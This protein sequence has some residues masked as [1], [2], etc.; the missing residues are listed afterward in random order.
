MDPL[1]IIIDVEASGFGE[2]SYPIE[3]GLAMEDSSSHCFLIKPEAGWQHWDKNSEKL[4]GVSRATL[5]EHG[6]DVQD[7]CAELNILLE[8]K[9]VY[10]DGWSYDQTWLHLLFNTAEQ[11][12]CFRIQSLVYLFDE[13]QMDNWHSEKIAMLEKTQIKRHRASNDAL[14]LQ[15]TYQAIRNKV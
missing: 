1:P 3:V 8:G 9:T 5:I 7:I 13:S 12:M 14:L 6:R 2:G 11:L 4:H 10:S 15:R